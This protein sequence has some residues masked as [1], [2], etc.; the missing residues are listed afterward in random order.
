MALGEMPTYLSALLKAE[1]STFLAPYSEVRDLIGEIIDQNQAAREIR[2]QAPTREL[3]DQRLRTWKKVFE[4]A[5]FLYVDEFKTLRLTKLGAEI[6]VTFE[7]LQDQAKYAE[8]H[9]KSLGLRVLCRQTLKNPLTKREYPS[10][11]DIRPFRTILSMARS[12][13]NKIH[14]EELNRVII[15]L[16]HEAEIPDATTLIAKTRPSDSE[17]DEA[18]LAVLG[19]P[20][21]TDRRRV[22]PILTEAGFGGSFLQDDGDGFWSIPAALVQAIDEVLELNETIPPNAVTVA[23]YLHYLDDGSVQRSASTSS[24]TPEAEKVLD[25]VSSYGHKKIVTLSGLPGTGKTRLA[26]E[27]AERLVDGDPYRLAEIQFHESTGYDQFIE[28]YVPRPDGAGFELRPMTLLNINTRALQDV[29]RRPH[30]LVIEEFTRANTHTVLGEFLTYVEHRN[31]PFRLSYSQAEVRIAENLI[32]L[33]TMNPQD[34]SAV[35]LDNAV[36]RR[37][38]QIEI[39]PNPVVLR[40]LSSKLPGAVQDKLISWYQEHH[41]RL[42]FG[43]GEFAGVESEEDLRNIWNGTLRYFLQDAMGNINP[44]YR[45]AVEDYPW[46]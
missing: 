29:Y 9:I 2:A 24:P 7:A 3:S 21:V 14:W 8:Q 42:P 36:K 34:R 28:G 38:F 44:L 19:D 20:V 25:A 39:Q 35:S 13:D 31:R 1:G 43:H 27:V 6:R 32:V 30:V 22:T 16:L 18:T 15:R 10:D 17:Y 41:L 37:L 23:D 33:A 26:R 12:L 11:C 5:G 46:N 4:E 45:E 40:K